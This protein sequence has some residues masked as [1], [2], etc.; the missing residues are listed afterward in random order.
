MWAM[1]CQMSI[2]ALDRELGVP[3]A[4]AGPWQASLGPA[5]GASH[6]AYGLGGLEA[7]LNSGG[8]T[9]TRARVRVP[10][11]CACSGEWRDH[12]QEWSPGRRVRGGG[13][14]LG[15]VVPRGCARTE[16]CYI[17]VTSFALHGW[18]SG[19]VA[20]CPAVFPGGHSR[21]LFRVLADLREPKISQLSRALFW[22]VGLTKKNKSSG[23][24]MGGNAQ[25]DPCRCHPGAGTG[26]DA[27]PQCPHAD[28]L[29]RW[30]HQHRRAGPSATA[31]GTLEV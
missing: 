29:S 5:S 14:C 4:S 21:C 25:F 31:N 30:P 28:Q 17:V 12:E 8:A 16:R 3:T 19:S 2:H 15:D 11:A 20:G 26:I 22:P 10:C 24:K 18:S 1:A 9:L 7:N 23:V 6:H 13:A 27:P